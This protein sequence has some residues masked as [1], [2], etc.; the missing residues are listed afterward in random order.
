MVCLDLFVNLLT[1]IFTV[2]VDDLL[3]FAGNVVGFVGLDLN[4]CKNFI[5]SLSHAFSTNHDDFHGPIRVS[6]DVT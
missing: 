3:N 1:M 6:W 2:D 5:A 4:F